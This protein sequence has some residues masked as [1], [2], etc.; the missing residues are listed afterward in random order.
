[1]LFQKNSNLRDVSIWLSVNDWDLVHW[2]SLSYINELKFIKNFSLNVVSSRATQ[3]NG[4]DRVPRPVLYPSNRFEHLQSVKIGLV[5]NCHL[6]TLNILNDLRSVELLH[7]YIDSQSFFPSLDQVGAYLFERIAAILRNAPTMR[8]LYLNLAFPNAW[9]PQ[10]T[11]G[12]FWDVSNLDELGVEF[13]GQ[14]RLNADI[15]FGSQNLNLKKL[16]VSG[17]NFQ[18]TFE[19]V[20]Q[21]YR[22]LTTL[23]VNESCRRYCSD[24]VFCIIKHLKKLESLDFTFPGNSRLNTDRFKTNQSLTLPAIKYV[25]FKLNE[26]TCLHDKLVLTEPIGN[27]SSLILETDVANRFNDDALLR[28]LTPHLPNLSHLIVDGNSIRTN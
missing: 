15:L 11:G 1:M 21:N 14:G 16:T 27:V 24:D 9:E 19:G 23:V 28:I 25:R 17:I 12:D 13:T 6:M 4:I 10:V 7:V 8:I 3:S 2:E 26:F 5:W 22:N 20:I 18:G